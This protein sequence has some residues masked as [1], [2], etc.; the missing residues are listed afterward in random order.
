MQAYGD[1]VARS[2]ATTLTSAHAP[3]LAMFKKNCAPEMHAT[4]STV[5]EV[6]A[7]G[8][9]NRP[10]MISPAQTGHL[11]AA[12]SGSFSVSRS[13]NRPPQNIPMVPNRYGMTSVNPVSEMLR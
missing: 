7:A 4:A 13:P 8:T 6:S 1:A 2:S 5:L 3:L 9:V 11:R 12:R 10:P